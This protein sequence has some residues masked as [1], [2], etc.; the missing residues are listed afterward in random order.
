MARPG[1]APELLALVA[2]AVNHAH[3]RGVVHR[4]LKPANVLVDASG[5]PKILDFGVATTVDPE[6]QLTTMH[7]SLGEVVGTL[8]YMSPEQVSGRSSQVD[9]RSDVYAL[10]VMAYEAFCGEP[11]FDLRG[12]L[13]H[14]AARIVMEEEPSTLGAH[15]TTL[16]GDVE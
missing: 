12:K 16:R 8:S 11:P 13:V 3:Q 15:D 2:D 5:E 6:A 10:G 7:T 9:A 1:G 14:E 4:D